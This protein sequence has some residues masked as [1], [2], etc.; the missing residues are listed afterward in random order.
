VL[1]PVLVTFLALAP[2][3]LN[4]VAVTWVHQSVPKVSVASHNT[5]CMHLI[6]LLQ[7]GVGPSSLLL[8]MLERV[9]PP[10]PEQ[11]PGACASPAVALAYC[12]LHLAYSIP[13]ADHSVL[14]NGAQPPPSRCLAAFSHPSFAFLV[15]LTRPFLAGAAATVSH[16]H[17]SLGLI[18]H[19]WPDAADPEIVNLAEAPPAVPI[20]ALPQTSPVPPYRSTLRP[21]LQSPI[22]ATSKYNDSKV[23]L[24]AA[25][26]QERKPHLH[27]RPAGL[28]PS[29]FPSATTRA[30]IRCR[31]SIHAVPVQASL[32]TVQPIPRLV[33]LNLVNGLSSSQSSPRPRVPCTNATSFHSAITHVLNAVERLC[34]RLASFNGTPVSDAA[35]S[36][37]QQPPQPASAA[38]PL[39]L[40]ANLPQPAKS[41]PVQIVTGDVQQTP[42][43]NGLADSS[44]LRCVFALDQALL[45]DEPE[46]TLLVLTR[47]LVI[48]SHA[49]ED[50][51][52]KGE[53]ELKQ[54]LGPVGW[55]ES[56]V[57]GQIAG[58]L[59]VAADALRVATLCVIDCEP[60][61]LPQPP[62]MESF[63]QV[64]EW[65]ET[66]R[67]GVRD[68]FAA[69][70]EA[71]TDLPGDAKKTSIDAVGS[72]PEGQVA[73]LQKAYPTLS[74][75]LAFLVGFLA[76]MGDTSDLWFGSVY[77][78]LSAFLP[79]LRAEGS[80]VFQNI[81]MACSDAG[82]PVLHDAVLAEDIDVVELLLM[83]GASPLQRA[84]M[85]DGTL[86]HWQHGTST[87]TNAMAPTLWSNT[88][89]QQ[90]L[91][92]MRP[93]PAAWKAVLD[94]TVMATCPDASAA[95]STVTASRRKLPYSKDAAFT[96]GASGCTDTKHTAA[97]PSWLC[98]DGQILVDSSVSPLQPV[99]AVRWHGPTAGCIPMS[100]VRETDTGSDFDEVRLLAGC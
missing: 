45:L 81:F 68:L 16:S 84:P 11:S 34:V 65:V 93:R 51:C 76:A 71:V 6:G 46:L 39:P 83:L 62:H 13:K 14:H 24:R 85:S 7:E 54:G 66:A 79:D 53:A 23:T 50:Y 8:R 25:A 55:L 49:A 40:A 19:M 30:P 96:P 15:F 31:R 82:L 35:S 86:V 26:L 29:A 95:A 74:Q 100:G 21:F 2:W 91:A 52:C 5:R 88:M 72:S 99:V 58:M 70:S 22:F 48:V 67:T 64:L 36:I 43:K 44:E 63:D 57:R 60:V 47:M 98:K 28:G 80:T 59:H 27:P 12:V 37:S 3:V 18:L 61:M 90:R 69:P 89:L 9:L 97:W 42:Q 78:R 94:P 41:S 92:H 75:T 32:G 87:A 20:S 38:T 33:A 1:H 56:S 10:P 4:A 17:V 73:S 77:G